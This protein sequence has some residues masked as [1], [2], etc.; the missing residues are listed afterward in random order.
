MTL[1]ACQTNALRARFARFKSNRRRP[2]ALDGT[3]VIGQPQKNERPTTSI[4][5]PRAAAPPRFNGRVWRIFSGII[6]RIMISIGVPDRPDA[7]KAHTEPGHAKIGRRWYCRRFFARCVCC[8]TATARSRAW[9][10]VILSASSPPPFSWPRFPCWMTCSRYL[11]PHQ[12]R[13]TA[14]RRRRRR[15]FRSLAACSGAA[16]FRHGRYR[17][18]RHSAHHVFSCFLSQTR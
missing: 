1:S 10:R 2:F 7:R 14:H 16:L 8:S 5:L 6:V 9:R 11:L 3:N 17:L 18:A 4:G 15:C 13:H 12:A